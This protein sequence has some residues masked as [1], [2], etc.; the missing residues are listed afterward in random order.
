VQAEEEMQPEGHPPPMQL[1]PEEEGKVYDEPLKEEPEEL[2]ISRP[3]KLSFG[4][5]IEG[6]KLENII[7]EF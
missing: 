4:E 5:A 3:M 2:I 6:L 1:R 7:P